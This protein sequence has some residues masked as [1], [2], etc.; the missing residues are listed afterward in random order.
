VNVVNADKLSR[1]IDA[2][3]ERL[4]I[5]QRGTLQELARHAEKDLGFKITSGSVALLMKHKG[6]PTNRVSKAET[7][8]MALLIENEK[9]RA[10]NKKLKKVIAAI[11]ASESLDPTLQEIVFEG[12]DEEMRNAIFAN[13]IISA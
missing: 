5:G 9:L 4:S 6:I 13:S 12:L 1:W 10:E 11:A 2:N 7:E 8:R 3:R